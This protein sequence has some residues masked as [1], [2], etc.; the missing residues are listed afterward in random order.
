MKR[1]ETLINFFILTFDGTPLSKLPPLFD[2]LAEHAPSPKSRALA[3]KTAA[4][5]RDA[6]KSEILF[7][8]QLE[9]DITRIAEIGKAKPSKN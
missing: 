4:A 3:S 2:A 6:E 1:I 5:L 7:F 9:K 8:G